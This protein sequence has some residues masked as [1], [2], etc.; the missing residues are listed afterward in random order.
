MCWNCHG[1]FSSIPYLSESLYSH[2]INI[3]ALSEQRTHQLHA[4]NY[5]DNKYVVYG[6]GTDDVN[7]ESFSTRASYKSEVEFSLN[8]V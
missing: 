2:D 8:F 1:I 4:L 3:C 6:K 7:P 5:I